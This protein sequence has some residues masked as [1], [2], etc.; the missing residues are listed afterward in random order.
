MVDDAFSDPF[1][2]TVGFGSTFGF[3][4][5]CAS[6]F[7]LEFEFNDETSD[8]LSLIVSELKLFFL[9]LFPLSLFGLTFGV[10]GGFAFPLIIVWTL[11]ID[12]QACALPVHP[13]WI[14]V[15]TGVITGT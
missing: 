8:P 9:R 3:S 12:P 13:L 2:L 11:L 10:L 5:C 7:S 1:L 15:F 4:F 14:S 6:E